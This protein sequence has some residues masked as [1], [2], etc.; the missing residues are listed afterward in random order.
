MYYIPDSLS[1]VIYEKLISLITS[2]ENEQLK[3]INEEIEALFIKRKQFI[4]KV[5]ERV[6]PMIFE[7]CSEVENEYPEEFI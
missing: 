5:G 1:D 6:N 2:E 3:A 4:S 7:K